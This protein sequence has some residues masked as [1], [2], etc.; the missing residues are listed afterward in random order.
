MEKTDGDN[1]P[2]DQKFIG[3]EA[4]KQSFSDRDLTPQE[5]E[6][7]IKRYCDTHGI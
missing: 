1:F 4:F 6:R 5:Y 2:V 7:I 3:Y